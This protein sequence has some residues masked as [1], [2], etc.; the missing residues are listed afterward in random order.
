[1]YALDTRL[2]LKPGATKSELER[3][4]APHILAQ[5]QYMGTYGR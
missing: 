1:L 3:A 5:T 2:D 4:M